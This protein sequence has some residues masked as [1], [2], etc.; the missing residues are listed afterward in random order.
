MARKPKK[1]ELKD[2]VIKNNLLTLRFWS[3]SF[4]TSLF[5]KNVSDLNLT[6]QF[7]LAGFNL[8]ILKNIGSVILYLDIA[9]EIYVSKVKGFVA[10]VSSESVILQL[11]LANLRLKSAWAMEWETPSAFYDKL[12]SEKTFFKTGGKKLEEYV[13]PLGL[14]RKVSESDQ[15]LRRRTLSYLQT[16]MNEDDD[17]SFSDAD[18]RKLR[19]DA[20][21]K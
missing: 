10:S 4:T 18:L 20:D 6:C 11:S 7:P 19:D 14:S 8:E 1:P 2:F 15:A 5:D 3:Q 16:Q 12:L 17:Y 9:D 21:G 13:K